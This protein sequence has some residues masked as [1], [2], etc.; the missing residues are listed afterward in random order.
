MAGNSKIGWTTHTV[1]FWTGCTKVS[2]ECANCY[3]ARP[4]RRRGLEP[5][6]GP[7]RTAP[8]TW[9]TAYQFNREAIAMGNTVRIFTCSM[10]DFFHEGA[11]EWRDDAWQVIRECDR[12]TWQILTKRPDRIVDCLPS[13]WGDGWPHVWLG[14][15]AGCRDSFWR[16]DELA[17][18]PA[19]CRFISAEPLLEQLDLRPY[20][21]DYQWI[22]SGCERAARDKRRH[23]DLDWVRDIDRQC[24]EA[25]VAHYFKQYYATRNG[26]E[27]GNP[28]EDCVL[29]G[30]VIAEF[31][32]IRS[33]VESS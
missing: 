23:M 14:V 12:V 32:E 11:D 30:R 4:M 7:I 27:Y 13:D 20:L 33:P 22:I 21:A 5:F 28:A 10:S 29:D 25:G 26:K 6:N 2:A 19:V 9:K 1:N 15:T 8:S 18:I 31:P 16:L 24:R 17:K 3:I